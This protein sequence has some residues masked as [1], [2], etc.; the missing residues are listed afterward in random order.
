MG[1]LGRLFGNVKQ[2]RLD[3]EIRAEQE[4]HRE[5][6]AREM[7]A[8]GMS[9]DEARRASRLR[10]GNVA[11]AQEDTRRQDLLPW[12]DDF[13]RELRIAL[14]GLRRSP[15]YSMVVIAALG[16]G[17]GANTAIFSLAHGILFRALP[18][19]DPDQLAFIYTKMPNG[20]RTWANYEDIQDWKKDSRS[21][22]HIA[23]WVSQSANLTGIGEPD[24][25]RAGFVSSDF[26]QTVGIQPMGRGF[27]AEELAKNGARA[28]VASWGLWQQKFGGRQDF[29]GSKVNLNGEPYTVVGIMPKEFLFPLDD[30]D[31]WMPYTTWPAY[32]PGRAS[33]NAGAIG[34]LNPQVSLQTA[35]HELNA[36]ARALSTQYPDSN[37]DRVGVEVMTF[38]AMLVQDL[39]P[40]LWILGGAVLM[41][42]LVACANI[43][44]LTVSRVLTRGRELS[45]RTA[46][47]ARRGRL[48]VHVFSE[49]LILS[50]VGAVLGLLVAYWFTKLAAVTE[51]LP[52]MANPRVDWPVAAACAGLSVAAALLTGPLP[53]VSLLRG[54][55]LDVSA[56]SRGGTETIAANR[57]RRA[58]V[59]VSIA[60][61]VMLLA[62]AGMLLRSFQALANVDPGFQPD[63]LLTM[64]YR[65]P[66]TKYT[67]DSMRVDFH[68]RVA[69]AA[70][71]VPGVRSATVMMALPFS[72][73]GSFTPFELPGQ[74]P[75]RGSEPR[76][77]VNRVDRAYFETMGIPL[78]KGRGIADAD[79][80]GADRVVVVSQSMADR[81]WPGQDPIGQRVIVKAFGDEPLIVVGV[82]GDSKHTS[83]EEESRDKAYLAF[84][85]HPH[86]FGTLAV[87]TQGDAAGYATLIRQAVWSVDRDQPVWKVRTMEALM[88]QRMTMRRLLARLT[89]SFSLF[90]LLLAS[91]GLYGVVSY[92]T[93]RRA[94]ELSI[95]AAMGATRMGL[96]RL[97]LGQGLLSMAVGLIAG[98]GCAILSARWLQNMLFQVKTTDAEPYLMAAGALSLAALAAILLPARKAAAANP[99]EALRQD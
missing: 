23:A 59:A 45:I 54:K 37:K 11:L 43:A 14:R 53:V 19:P 38:H 33:I 57:T 6:A 61:S 69:E 82:V 20:R 22:R 89:G 2:Q 36:R 18:H 15:A 17:V 76:A 83:L 9:P 12:L 90:A 47:G 98:V 52:A 81:C 4:Y 75:S 39:K 66:Q 80:L 65:M 55:L 70:A 44:T 62:G 26:F 64:E 67:E 3:E 92:S 94:R 79:R 48:L 16:L 30:I 24:R 41:A 34:R 49:Q 86:I 96:V 29:L 85:Q 99:V 78:L 87:R 73:N 93:T 42:L 32:E 27:L 25:L 91:I 5:L 88:D 46:L 50:A 77:Q 63:H 51:M 97:V 68:R 35:Q 74:T 13:W 58:L 72:G 84:A 40:L 60:L 21:F 31:V 10:F 7:E 1:L 28:A 56:S 8:D 71:R 95:R